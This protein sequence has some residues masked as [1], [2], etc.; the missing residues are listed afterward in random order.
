MA[1]VSTALRTGV[2]DVTAKA[3]EILE[4]VAYFVDQVV[5]AP[6]GLI[7]NVAKIEASIKSFD[8]PAGSPPNIAAQIEATRARLI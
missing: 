7:A 6:G 2:T 5:P 8:K 4:D 1:A 3:Q